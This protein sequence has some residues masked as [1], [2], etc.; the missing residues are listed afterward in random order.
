ME[1]Q[2]A[3][4]EPSV[5]DEQTPVEALDT[6]EPSA[7][8]APAVDRVDSKDI[9]EKTQARINK[10]TAEKHAGLRRAEAAEAKVAELEANKP[11]PV[12]TGEPKLEDFDFDETAHT[13]ALIDY[14]VN[15][16]AQEIQQQQAE[17]TQADAAIVT[18]NAFEEK[19]VAFKQKAPDFQQVMESIPILPPDV[20]DAI[21]R[22]EKGPEI[23][24]YLGKHL[25]VA[26]ELTTMMRDDALMKVGGLS[27]QI[28]AT[29]KTIDKSAAPDPI[30]PINSG[31]SLNKEQ[32]NMTIEELDALP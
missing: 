22:N 23:V 3:L 25:D 2:A 20:R 31:G 18:Q 26:D 11:K 27:A 8:P 5:E 6:Q 7:D 12:I 1:E 19:V 29:T 32:E 9:T 13:S 17:Q 24:Y 14:K 4:E 30:K 21:M 10:I 15:Q 28:S 16:K